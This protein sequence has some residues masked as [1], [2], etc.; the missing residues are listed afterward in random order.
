MIELTIAGSDQMTEV[1]SLD[2]VVDESLSVVDAISRMKELETSALLV[3]GS[4]G[5]LTGIF[6]E[7]DA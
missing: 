4:D 2:F 1:Q 7:R 5:S 6:T 3:S